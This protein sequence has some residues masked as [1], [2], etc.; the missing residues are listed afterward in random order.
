MMLSP[1]EII[2]M[3]QIETKQ[4]KSLQKEPEKIL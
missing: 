3:R 4:V 2:A 1:N